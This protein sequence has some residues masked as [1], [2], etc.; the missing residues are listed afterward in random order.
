MLLQGETCGNGGLVM[1]LDREKLSQCDVTTPIAVVTFSSRGDVPATAGA[2]ETASGTADIPFDVA[3][4]SLEPDA[5]DVPPTPAAAATEVPLPSAEPALLSSCVAASPA[6]DPGCSPGCAGAPTPG[7]LP[8]I[9]PMEPFSPPVEDR[10][11]SLLAALGALQEQVSSYRLRAEAAE[12]SL[13]HHGSDTTMQ[14]PASLPSNLRGFARDDLLATLQR[15]LAACRAERDHLSESMAAGKAGAEA[16]VIS[17]SK[18]LTCDASVATEEALAVGTV[19]TDTESSGEITAL[20]SRATALERERKKLVRQVLALQQQL[21]RKETDVDG[22][23]VSASPVQ[24]AFTDAC[25][26]TDAISTVESHSDSDA[27][28]VSLRAEVEFSTAYARSVSAK[29]AAA[30]DTIRG[31]KVEL[32]AAHSAERHARHEAAAAVAECQRLRLECTSAA[33]K[34]NHPAH[35]E[36][37]LENRQVQVNDAN[38]VATSASEAPAES[39]DPAPA[40]H[41]RRITTSVS[42]RQA[43]ELQSRLDELHARQRRALGETARRLQALGVSVHVPV[44][45]D[46]GLVMA[47]EAGTAPSG[48]PTPASSQSAVRRRGRSRSDSGRSAASGANARTGGSV[49]SS[50]RGFALRGEL[51]RLDSLAGELGARTGSVAQAAAVLQ[52]ALEAASAQA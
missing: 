35:V 15:D 1:N 23:H 8:A 42:R 26:G 16:P 10:S 11:S 6:Q 48:S 43:A 2:D 51:S 36:P 22:S 32:A 30:L 19:L 29:A 49:L 9:E 46:V 12:A 28:I 5:A 50:A 4:A 40:S 18:P 31:L 39:A 41:R 17:P 47:A 52:V 24:V 44:D 34:E 20:R 38:G 3:T 37:P 7:T 25:V 33:S 21:Q 27:Q 13:A 14:Q 45:A